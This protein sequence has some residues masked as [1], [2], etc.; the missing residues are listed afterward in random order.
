MINLTTK[1]VAQIQ[2]ISERRVRAKIKQGHYPN[3]FKC[4]CGQAWLI[5][6]KDLLRRST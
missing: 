1:Q 2:Q 6:D 4:P 5:P 3:A